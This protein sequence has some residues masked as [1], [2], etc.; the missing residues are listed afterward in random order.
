MEKPLKKGCYTILIFYTML[1]FG[2]ADP[3]PKDRISEIPLLRYDCVQNTLHPVRWNLEEQTVVTDEKIVLRQDDIGAVL[4]MEWSGDGHL[5]LPTVFSN[6]PF[7]EVDTDFFRNVTEKEYEKEVVYG[8]WRCWKADTGAV[9]L[10][11]ANHVYPLEL[12]AD[13]E[14][15]GL[16]DPGEGVTILLW[17]Q[18]HG[19]VALYQYDTKQQTGSL[20]PVEG[21]P[22]LMSSQLWL[23]QV[24]IE[25]GENFYFTDGYAVYLIDSK[26][27][28]AERVFSKNAFAASFANTDA[29]LAEALGS[30]VFRMGIY[31]NGLL[32]LLGH[33]E[34]FFD[35]HWVYYQSEEQQELME[36]PENPNVVYLLPNYG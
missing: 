23:E 14:L 24:A 7:L 33:P 2:C 19:Q 16:T 30:C 32:V 34:G 13:Y 11:D 12:D 28:Q 36:L 3:E 22:H 15:V 26:T 5:L 35:T 25:T 27:K 1:L 10:A 20:E 4:S 29:T 21:F 18:L 6:R 9:M 17:N 31:Q 8:G